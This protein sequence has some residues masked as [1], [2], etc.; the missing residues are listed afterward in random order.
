MVHRGVGDLGQTWNDTKLSSSGR[1]R[2]LCIKVELPE[3]SS[4][5][6]IDLDIT[7][8]QL[9]LSHEGVGYKLH[10]Q[11]PYPVMYDQGSAKFDKAKKVL[12]ITVPVRAEVAPMS[13]W[14]QLTPAD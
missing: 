7:E 9:E 14:T 1:P 12:S 3:L 6:E 4:A 8:R 2:E 5:A 11:L 10:V 13:H